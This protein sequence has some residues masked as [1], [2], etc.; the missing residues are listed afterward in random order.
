MPLTFYTSSGKPYAYSEDGEQIYTFSGLPLGYLYQDSIYNYQGD[1]IGYFS[2]GLLRDR[3][4]RVAL[5]TNETSAGPTQ[6][7]K[8][9]S[10]SRE[11]KQ[12]LPEKAHRSE[13]SKRPMNRMQW[14]SY[15]VASLF[16]ADSWVQ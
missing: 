3:L 12:P 11:M 9:M 4:G 14:S 6:P 5:F 15:P 7:S 16:S 2:N 13:P 10:P 8:K 1:H